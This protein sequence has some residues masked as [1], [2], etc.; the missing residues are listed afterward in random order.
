MLVG[1]GLPASPTM[2][3]SPPSDGILSYVVV[4]MAHGQT[5][6]ASQGTS[7]IYARQALPLGTHGRGGNPTSLPVVAYSAATLPLPGEVAAVGIVATLLAFVARGGLSLAYTR[8]A[9]PELLT[10][11]VRRRVHALVAAEPGIH[12][13]GVAQRIGGGNGPAEY[14]LRVLAREGY[15]ASVLVRGR[16]HYFVAGKHTPAEMRALAA[17]RHGSAERMYALVR[18]HPGISVSAL[19]ARAGMT[20]ANASKTALRLEAA[21]LVERV[22]E[23]RQVQLRPRAAR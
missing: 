3:P 18:A 11:A 22:R 4:E 19:A 6:V 9:R 12:A 8:L 21:G 2:L 10:Q 7:Q 17:L 5:R 23:G 20:A 16:R 13:R 15:L 1:A 14:H